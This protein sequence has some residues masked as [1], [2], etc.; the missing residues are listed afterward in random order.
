M[1]LFPQRRHQTVKHFVVLSAFAY[2]VNVLVI[3][4]LH[5]VV[6]DNGAFHNQAAFVPQLDI[7]IDDA[8]YYNHVVIS[9]VG[10]KQVKYPLTHFSLLFQHQK[11]NL[12]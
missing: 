10:T 2:L 3:D 12:R 9:C 5:L 11:S 6:D 4:G 8:L 1:D 7:G